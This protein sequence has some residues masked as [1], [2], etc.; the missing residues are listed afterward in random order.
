[1]VSHEQEC[2]YRRPQNNHSK[3]DNKKGRSKK[4]L[5]WRSS[6]AKEH[7][8]LGLKDGSIPTDEAEHGHM[9][10]HENCCLGRPEFEDFPFDRLFKDRLKRLRIGRMLIWL[11]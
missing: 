3:K 2:R 11:L 10:V 7:L 6:S 5:T 4:A 8:C 9:A 1:L